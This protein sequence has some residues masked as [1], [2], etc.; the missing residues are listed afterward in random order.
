MTT[1][2]A[3]TT[4]ALLPEGV[5]DS[6]IS[7]LGRHAILNEQRE[8]FGYEI[9]GQSYTVDINIANDAAALLDALSYT[10]A[11]TLLKA[12][13]IFVDCSHAALIG[14]HLEKKPISK[15]VLQVAPLHSDASVQEIEAYV[16]IFTPL[17]RR[18]LRL[19]FDQQVLRNAYT[20]WLPM[21]SFIKLDMQTIAMEN[22][23]AVVKF[24]RKHT[25]AQIIADR[26]ETEAQFELM[27]T[28]EVRLFQ[29]PWFAKA[30]AIQV[31]PIRPAQTI[32]LQLLNLVR[33]QGSTAEI[34]DLLKKDPTL[35]FNLL[36]LINSSGFGL[37][38]EIASFRHA[39][40]IL[41]LKR[42]FRWAALL[43]TT[44]RTNASVPAI[45]QTAVVRGRFMELLATEL[46]SANEEDVDNAFLVGLFSL[47]DVMLGM[48]L[49]KALHQ[50]SLPQTVSDT[51]LHHQG[52]FAP[53]LAIVQACEDGSSRSLANAAKTLG[54]SN[55]QINSAHLQALAW[56]DN[57]TANT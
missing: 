41:G 21:A 11:D 37:S 19:A 51:L 28:L 48:P 3:S 53:L 29:G 50:V 31:R 45:G 27:Q 25:M 54:L 1:P 15:A 47:L 24:V 16:D 35:S 38:S 32:V 52:T 9:F 20:K 43:M 14:Q 26:V 8:I 57:L 56:A 44:T 49:D 30:D 17:L 46:L 40:M 22:I 42:L 10:H 34:E 4:T 55:H 12:K 33:N 7:L 6:T 39:V 2:Q 13:T 23:E 36:R 18:G 5:Q